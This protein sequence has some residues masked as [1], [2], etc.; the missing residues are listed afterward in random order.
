MAG[1]AP[2]GGAV[3]SGGGEG[4]EG[5]LAGGVTRSDVLGNGLEA[6]EI[7]DVGELVA[8]LGQKRGVHDDAEGLVAIADAVDFAVLTE[9]V[10]VVGG[11]L[12]VDGGVGQVVAVVAPGVQ[13]GLVAALEQGGHVALVHLGGQ[14]GAVLAGSRGDDLD[15]HAG[16][17]GIE[18]G[19]LLPGGV[20]L[21]LEVQV[22]DAAG[23]G[24]VA[25]LGSVAGL[26][27]VPAARSVARVSRGLAAGRQREYHHESEKQ[28]KKL[29]HSFDIS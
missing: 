21:G 10:E 9:E 13:A 8:G 2:A 11:H 1:E 28:C 14:R 12:L 17:L 19:E 23:R 27:V 7:R 25:A 29:L 26:G 3:K 16:L 24:A 6:L 5:Q 15:G 20:S 18:S 4:R 22:I